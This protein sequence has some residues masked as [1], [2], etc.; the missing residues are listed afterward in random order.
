MK[1]NTLYLDMDGVVA[2]FDGT[3]ERRLGVKTQKIANSNY[4]ITPEQW[5]QLKS[6]G[7]VFRELS[8]MPHADQL[9]EVAR[10]FRD[11][12]S[13]DLYFLTAIPSRN[14]V[15]DAFSEKVMWAQQHFPDI[16]V[17]FGPFAVDKQRHCRP[18]DI[19]VD[20]RMS[21]CDDW[22]R[23]GGRAIWVETRDLTAAVQ[24][25]RA[26]LDQKLSLKRLSEM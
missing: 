8:V 11:Q 13:W 17:R 20:D 21:N 18:G 25:L 15:P 10:Q 5:D 12:L 6:L 24:Q 26:I 9:V 14:D 2:D 22:T 1:K 16:S 19:L 23:S 4:K 3:A 7:N